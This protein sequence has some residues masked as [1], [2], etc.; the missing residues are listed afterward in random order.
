[1]KKNASTCK[2][3]VFKQLFEQYAQSLQNFIFYKSGR[4]DLSEDCVQEAFIRLWKNCSKVPVEKAKSYLFTVANNLFLD[5]ARHQKVVLEFQKKTSKKSIVENPEYL[6]QVEEFRARL[7]EAI[8]Q[9]PETQ[10]TVFLM[11]RIDGMK[12][13]EIAVALEISQKAVEK[14]MHKAL[15]ELRKLTGKI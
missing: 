9:L 5:D 10:R 8:N 14:R 6:M 3:A 7:M 1:M 4:V 2:K 15:I 13:R 12:Y 11:N